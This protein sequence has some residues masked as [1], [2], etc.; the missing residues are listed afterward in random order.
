M[1]FESKYYGTIDGDSTPDFIKISEAYVIE[2][3]KITDKNQI[4]ELEQKLND[5]KSYVIEVELKNKTYVAPKLA[6][7]RLI[8]DQEP[9]VDRKEFE[10][11]MI[12]DAYKK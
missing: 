3:Y 9:L 7:G 6:M 1:Y 4:I 5:D 8:E 10:D 2:S 12:I 11:N